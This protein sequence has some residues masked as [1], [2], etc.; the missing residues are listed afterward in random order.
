MGQTFFKISMKYCKKTI[1]AQLSDEVPFCLTLAW[2][3]VFGNIIRWIP[4]LLKKIN[5]VC[6]VYEGI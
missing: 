1:K 2:L 5:S 4:L 3:F 6:I